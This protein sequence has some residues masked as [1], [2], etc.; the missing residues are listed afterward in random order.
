M[1]TGLSRNAF[2]RLL[3]SGN[4]ECV[5]GHDISKCKISG[6]GEIVIELK[7]ICGNAEEAGY[8]GFLCIVLRSIH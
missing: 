1:K 8:T 5:S 7:Q 6:K 4:L 2:A 3:S